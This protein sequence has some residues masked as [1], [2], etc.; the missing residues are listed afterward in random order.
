MRFINIYVVGGFLG[1][2]SVS[3]AVYLALFHDQNRVAA[4][5]WVSDPIFIITVHVGTCS[6]QASYSIFSTER[7]G[8]NYYRVTVPLNVRHRKSVPLLAT[9]LAN[10]QNIHSNTPP[11]Q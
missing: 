8:Y 1:L 9:M 2:C 7:Q 4:L 3:W 11:I 10:T 5:K 6:S